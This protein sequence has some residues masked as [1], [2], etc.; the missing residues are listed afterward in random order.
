MGF[1]E[2]APFRFPDGYESWYRL[3]IS[4]VADYFA[5]LKALREKYKNDIEIKI[6]FE[7]EY[8]P[9]HIDDMIKNAINYGAEYL[10]LGHHY[11]KN[12]HPNGIHVFNQ[13]ASV[14]D[15]EEYVSCVIAGAKSGYFT[16][17]AHPDIFNFIG[18]TEIYKDK[19]RRI[20]I[21][22]RELNMPLEINFMGI[23]S[24]RNYPNEIFWQLAGEENS[25]V[26]F[27]SDAH[28]AKS[29]FDEESFKI[30]KKIVEKYNLNYIGEPKLVLIQELDHQKEKV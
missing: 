26:T 15:L 13:N 12:E 17:I 22:S 9:L 6:G 20:C 7:V 3:P 21:A 2:H 24:N 10:I 27:G 4:E 14:E 5:E 25:P 23:R 8:Y 1:S 28:D 16:Y 18:D 29:A 19:M 30:A 11:L